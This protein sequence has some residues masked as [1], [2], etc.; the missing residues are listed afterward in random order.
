MKYED[1]EL[2]GW[3]QSLENNIFTTG[4]WMHL[5]I[6]SLSML[7]FCTI[8]TTYFMLNGS[9]EGFSDDSFVTKLI[10]TASRGNENTISLQ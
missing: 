4:C 3:R 2:S 6:V 5:I 8:L 10:T 9:S 7:C 1:K